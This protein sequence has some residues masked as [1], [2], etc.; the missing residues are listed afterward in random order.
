MV[1]QSCKNPSLIKQCCVLTEKSKYKSI[2]HDL[3]ILQ[4]A[5][6]VLPL[7][8]LP[9]VMRALRH[10]WLRLPQNPHTAIDHRCALQ[11][12]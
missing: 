4:R 5:G 1:F 2:K 8:R 9:G 12:V 10:P 6:V 3:C 11:E 7:T